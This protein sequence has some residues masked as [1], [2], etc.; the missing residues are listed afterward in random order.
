MLIGSHLTILIRASSSD[1]H[2]LVFL[3]DFVIHKFIP[4]TN[5][6]CV[7]IGDCICQR[8]IGQQN[9]L[10]AQLEGSLFIPVFDLAMQHMISLNSSDAD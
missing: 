6:M 5:F 4:P 7:Q 3:F 1:F 8:I 2:L 10:I 9:H